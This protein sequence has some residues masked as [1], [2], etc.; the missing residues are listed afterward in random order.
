MLPPGSVSVIS[1]KG[2]TEVNTRY[3]YQLDAADNL[4]PGIIS[5]AV[6]HKIDHRYPKLLQKPLINME[7]NTV[8][9]PIK[10]VICKLK[11]IDVTDAE[12]NNISWTT[13]GT[14]TSIK[15][16]ELP[17]MS[18]ESGFW[19]EHNIS[20]LI[21]VLEDAHILQKAKDLLSSFH[22]E[23]YN[24]IISKLPMNVQWTN[25]FQMDIL[26]TG[27]PVTWK[28]YPILLTYQKFVN[29]KI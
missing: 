3:L 19:P 27:P 7:H 21:I 14:T 28:P 12:V 1:V 2:P 29:G 10:A 24:S 25:P 15:P 20:K 4:P 11:P 16:A 6:D 23:E 26:T 9:I 5:L 13:D 8:D 22:K 17:C 18:P